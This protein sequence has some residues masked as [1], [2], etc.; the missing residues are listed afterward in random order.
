[1][2]QLSRVKR[3]LKDFGSITQFEAFQFL[4]IMRL[5]SRISELRSA[6]EEIESEMVQVE[7]RFGEK[8]WVKRYFYSNKSQKANEQGELKC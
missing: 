3:F 4:G 1:M 5:A 6:G 7:N 8:C 2:T